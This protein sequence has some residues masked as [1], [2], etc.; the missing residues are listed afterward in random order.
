MTAISDLERLGL[1]LSKLFISSTKMGSERIL[2][3]RISVFSRNG[4]CSGSD[5]VS[6]PSN[7]RSFVRE[8]R[9]WDW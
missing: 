1:R 8:D 6:V 3:S 2:P 9:S 7:S 4:F 5:T